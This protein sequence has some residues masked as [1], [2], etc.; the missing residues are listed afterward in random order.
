MGDPKLTLDQVRHVAKLASLSLS[1]ADLAGQQRRLADILRYFEALDG[2]DVTDVEPT[3]HPVAL[4]APARPDVVQP[5]QPRERYL[6][7]APKTE[8][9]GF[10]VPKVLDGD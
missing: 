9:G 2:V 8:A 6:A 1:E 5:P 7:A 10:A 4:Q 3:F